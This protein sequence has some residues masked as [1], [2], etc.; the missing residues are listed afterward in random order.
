MPRSVRRSW[1]LLAALALAPA[2]AHQGGAPASAGEQQ[3]L[4]SADE[5]I[6]RSITA[7]GGEAALRAH[8]AVRMTGTFSMAAQGIQ[9]QMTL[10]ATAEGQMY[11]RVQIEG[12][13]TMEEGVDG[14][15]VWSKDPL[16]G[17]RL[18]TGVEATQAKRAADFYLA[19][20]LPTH[21][22]T[23]ETVRQTLLDGVPVWEVRLV[24][25]EGP[26]EIAWFDTQSGL[27]L[28]TKM[29]LQTA[30]GDVT[31]TSTNQDFRAAGGVTLPFQTSMKNSLMTSTITWTE[32]VWDPA[33]L[34][35]PAVPD[36]VRALAPTGVP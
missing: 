8:R 36:D 19:L 2:C 22:P 27:E 11:S 32:I 15:L 29:T 1:L 7:Q 16:A 6:A 25:A 28:G 23:R 18:K 34:G 21:Y 17:P 14:A 20:D 9:G 35:M 5:L 31:V 13:G 12:I 24:P 10:W 4:P 30:M 3:A 26:E 33:D